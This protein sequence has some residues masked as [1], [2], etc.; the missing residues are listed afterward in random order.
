MW[1]TT[2]INNL[3]LYAIWGRIHIIPFVSIYYKQLHSGGKKEKN[4]ILAQVY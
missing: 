2:E 4:Y 3:L 1:L